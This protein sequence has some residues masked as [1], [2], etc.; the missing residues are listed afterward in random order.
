MMKKTAL[1]S[2]I[3]ILIP[4]YYLNGNK[5]KENNFILIKNMTKNR[6]ITTWLTKK[7]VNF[8]FL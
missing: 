5:N 8:T 3:L 6:E 7:W 1:L 4:F 2:S